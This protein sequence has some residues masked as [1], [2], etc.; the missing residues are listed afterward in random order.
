MNKYFL[1]ALLFPFVLSSQ[2]DD[3]SLGKVSPKTAEDKLMAGNFED[4]I[5]D[6][7]AL[8][9]QDPQNEKYA[10]NL[11]VCYLNYNGNKTKA[12][13][14]LEK[15]THNAKHDPNAD[16]LLGRAY[17]YAL[18]FD[19]AISAFNKFTK[20]GKGKEEN[21]KDA[22]L[23]IQY[24]LNA[25]ERVKYPL[26]VTFENLNKPVNSEYSDYYPFIPLDESFVIYNSKRPIGD[27]EQK[28]NGE[29]P[30]V[31][32]YS[33]VKDGKYQPAKKL[34]IELPKGNTNAEVIGLSA[35]GNVLLLY[36][37]DSKGGGSIYTSERVSD[38]KYTKPVVLDKQI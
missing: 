10:Y 30:A 27:I 22:E 16:Y 23:Q 38:N 17:Q 21:L 36:I 37:N 35:N 3:G 34:E 4:A 1:I 8:H 28:P 25:K 33:E 6:Y 18:R 32:L 31:I 26:N 19:D 13:P 24:C 5:A 2:T 14:Y 12:V 15:I 20:T 9:A 7:V 11:A 29:Y